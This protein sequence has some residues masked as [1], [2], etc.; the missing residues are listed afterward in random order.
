[1]AWENPVQ[2]GAKLAFSVSL[3]LVSSGYWMSPPSNRLNLSGVFSGPDYQG[4][5]TAA[6]MRARDCTDGDLWVFAYGSLM[7]RPDFAAEEAQDALLYGWHR[8]LCILS[9]RYRGSEETP[10]LVLGLDRGG[11][12]RGVAYRIRADQR[13]AVADYLD[14]RELATRSYR[15]GFHALR[16]TDGRQVEAYGYVADPTHPQYGGGLADADRVALIRQG[17]GSAGTC[18]EYLRFTLEHLTRMGVRDRGLERIWALVNAP[19]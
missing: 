19:D 17:R 14:R 5:Q 16:L 2:P 12:C 4:P 11:S 3:L 8:A 9:V 18:V 15:P 1:M 6:E 13:A 7:W 10:G